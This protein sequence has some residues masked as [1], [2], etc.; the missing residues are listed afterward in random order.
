MSISW[1]LFY[2]K[3]LQETVIKLNNIFRE[4]SLPMCPECIK[5]HSEEHEQERVT[6][7]IDLFSNC[8]TE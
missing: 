1:G 6:S 2:S 5:I 3:F 4:C 7:D 8:L